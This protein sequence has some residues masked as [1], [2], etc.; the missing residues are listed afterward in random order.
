MPGVDSRALGQSL[1][2]D[3]AT[4]AIPIVLVTGMP[5]FVLAPFQTDGG[6]W[7]YLAKPFNLD[8]LVA[9]VRAQLAPA[10]PAGHS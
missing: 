9:T 10:A 8:D 6:A 5:D 7:G 3:R 2:A 1:R 4:Q